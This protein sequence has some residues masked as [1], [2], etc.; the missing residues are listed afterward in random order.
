MLSAIN[1]VSLD[2]GKLYGDRVAID[3]LPPTV[4]NTRFSAIRRLL[5]A[6]LFFKRK[7]PAEAGSSTACAKLITG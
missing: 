2:Q 4:V 6:L 1:I 3:D 5:T 7:D